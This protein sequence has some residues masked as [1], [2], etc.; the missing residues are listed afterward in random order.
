[1]LRYRR[2]LLLSLA[3]ILSV[4]LAQTLP[5]GA[6]LPL[7]WSVLGVALLLLPFA[8]RRKGFLTASLALFLAVTA[9]FSSYRFSRTEEALRPYDG[10]VVLASATLHEVTLRTENGISG[11]GELRFRSDTGEEIV[12][13]V[14]I[15]AP[16]DATAGDVLYGGVLLTLAD[17]S[18]SYTRAAGLYGSASFRACRVVDHRTG[19]RYTVGELREALTERIR[20]AVPSEEGELLA[21]LLL[22]VRDGLSDTLSRDMTRIGTVH[23]LSLSGLHLALL[24]GGLGWL[25]QR[26]RLGKRPRLLLLLLFSLAFVVFTGFSTSVMRAGFMLLFSVLPLFFREERDSLSSLGA[27]VALI[28][29]AAP[30]A[31]KDAAL[32]LSALSTLG[33]LL[34]FDRMRREEESASLPRRLLRWVL[35]A[36]AVTVAASV[37]TLPLTLTLYGTLPLL[38]PLANLLLG[39]LT[40]LALYASLFVAIFGGFPPVA[41]PAR[42][43][44]SLIIRLSHALGDLP[45]TVISV[46]STLALVVIFLL[47]GAFLLYFLLS[48]RKSFRARIPLL[49]CAAIL[50]SA[51]APPLFTRIVHGGD[52]S[53]LYTADETEATDCLY[54]EHK[55]ERLLIVF[56]DQRRVGKAERRAFSA[57]AGELDALLLPY[58]A[59]GTAEYLKTLLGEKRVRKLYLPMPESPNEHTLYGEVLTLARETDTVTAVFPRVGEFTF[60]SLTVARLYP[61][62]RDGAVAG[63]ILDLRLGERSVQYY[64]GDVLGPLLKATTKEADLLILGRH[65]LP[66]TYGLVRQNY[67]TDGAVLLC[68][69]PIAFPFDKKDGAYFSYEKRIL[70]D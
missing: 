55:G 12:A 34:L 69:A 22:G 68:A 14:R 10:A 41:I 28:C 66:K 9:L 50:V 20:T 23:I 18:D 45:K 64:S 29:L 25:L 42:L 6:K 44:C 70:L 47:V 37:A 13:R 53:V 49:L 43:L 39:P 59:A 51:V 17:G 8:F 4:F 60:E 11:E 35:T 38:S 30:Y 2:L 57:A 54:F 40:Q 52:L 65:R 21:A 36:L 7:L 58:Y 56:S 48:P 16:T 15:L 67:V 61:M 32:W 19:L 27:A 3:A 63:V 5:H 1:M 31:V 33:I 46:Q 26:L 62:N 24:T